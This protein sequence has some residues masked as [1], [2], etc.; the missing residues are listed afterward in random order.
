MWTAAVGIVAYPGHGIYQSI[1]TL[2]R[3]KAREQIT[4]AR[5]KEGDHLIR[6]DTYPVDVSFVLA[7]F[8]KR[9]VGGG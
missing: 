6:S 5:Q 4:E 2:V 8:E 3:S 9:L 7:E 1:R